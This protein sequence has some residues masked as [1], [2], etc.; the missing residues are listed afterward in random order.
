MASQTC[1]SFVCPSSTE[2]EA[3]F[4]RELAVVEFPQLFW[5]AYARCSS[6]LELPI[7]LTK[8]LCYIT[9]AQAI[10]VLLILL[11]TFSAKSLDVKFILN[12]G[13][14]NY[15]LTTSCCAMVAR[16]GYCAQNLH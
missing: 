11:C 16:L 14:Q 10:F 6:Q 3:K 1:C 12:L 15:S 9:V 2:S 8:V 4:W 5:E 13:Y 7:H